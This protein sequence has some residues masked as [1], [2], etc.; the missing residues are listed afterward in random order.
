[1]TDTDTDQTASV[2]AVGWL[3]AWQ[4][5]RMG[6]LRNEWRHTLRWVRERNWRAIRNTLNGYLA[7]QEGAGHCGHGWTKSRALRDLA[8]IHASN[9]W[10]THPCGNVRLCAMDRA[11]YCVR[12]GRS[13]RKWEAMAVE[14]AP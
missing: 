14:P 6:H 12:C 13:D 4:H 11:N 2:Y 7:E 3:A 1:M 8:R 10:A 5:R 9:A